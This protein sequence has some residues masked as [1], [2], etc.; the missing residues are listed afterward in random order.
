ML[1]WTLRQ[2]KSTNAATRTKAAVRLGLTED[3]RAIDPLVTLLRDSS[4]PTR[5]AAAEALT[6]HGWRPENDHDRSSW[7]IAREDWTEAERIGDRIVDALGDLLFDTD[8][9]IRQAAVAVLEKVGGAKAQQFLAE[10]VRREAE[11]EARVAAEEE[12]RTN[13]EALKLAQRNIRAFT[14]AIQTGDSPEVKFLLDLAPPLANLRFGENGETMLG[15]AASNRQPAIVQLLLDRHADV[16]AF[17]GSGVAA[18][19]WA[20]V[21][22]NTEVVG[23]LINAGCDVNLPDQFGKPPLHWAAD[24]GSASMTEYLIEKGADARAKDRFGA[25]AIQCLV[26]GGVNTIG[27]QV[28]DKFS[29]RWT[30]G[31]PRVLDLLLSHGAEVNGEAKF[32]DHPLQIAVSRGLKE[33]IPVLQRHTVVEFK[34]E[35]SSPKSARDEYRLVEDSTEPPELRQERKSQIIR[36]LVVILNQ[37]RREVS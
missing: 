20:T 5:R 35:I 29:S 4:R 14:H 23:I 17:D 7:V 28:K 13:A 9:E 31:A 19:H 24:I 15:F 25:T 33:L 6:S 8:S 30:A 2:A 16:S 11:E 32:R 22:D 18:I 26:T 27:E 12:A 37:H 1:W 21:A 34:R 3:S 36:Q 10:H